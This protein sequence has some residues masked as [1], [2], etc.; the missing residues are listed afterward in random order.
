MN[1]QPIS[2]DFIVI[3]NHQAMTNRQSTLSEHGYD[4]FPRQTTMDEFLPKQQTPRD[5]NSSSVAVA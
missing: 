5:T 1:K 4:I 3:S 2:H